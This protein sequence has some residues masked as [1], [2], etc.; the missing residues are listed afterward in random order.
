MHSHLVS[1]DQQPGVPLCPRCGIVAP[2]EERHCEVCAIQLARPAPVAPSSIDGSYWVAVRCSFQCRSCQFLSPL[3]ELDLD[4]R[5]ECGQCNMP[6]RFDVSAWADALHFA[7]E[8]G[9][10]AY[11][12]PEGRHPHPQIWIGSDNPHIRI[13]YTQAFGE[14]RQSGTRTENDEVVYRSLFIQAAP[15]HPVCSQCA[16]ALECALDAWGNVSTR[17]PH[18]QSASQ[19]KLPAPTKNLCDT[20]MAAVCDAHGVGR[21]QVKLE[22]SAGV[23]ALRCPECGSGLPGSREA[24]ITCH[25]CGVTALLPS[26]ARTRD[27]GQPQEP[28][29]WWLAFRGPSTK[30]H[31]LEWQP[32]LAADDGTDSA[33]EPDGQSNLKAMLKKKLSKD[34]SS[35]ELAPKRQGIHLQQWG[36]RLGLPALALAIG[37]VISK[38][39]DLQHLGF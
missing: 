8:V 29:I 11:P 2:S 19:Y 37:Y 18:C 38:L 15:G 27:V 7:H 5:V 32:D 34:Q 26:R 23:V 28:A 36:L 33:P 12:P 10:L 25:Y 24:L 35:L 6:Q 1:A 9:D 30:R 21:K 14:H 3:D 4:G 39:F 13:G 16:V 31:A 22:T 17:C 20:V